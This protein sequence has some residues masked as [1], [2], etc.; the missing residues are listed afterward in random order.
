MQNL[1]TNMSDELEKLDGEDSAI[2]N[3]RGWFLV[4]YFQTRSGD[5]G[6]NAYNL[7]LE[8]A[9]SIE[10]QTGIRTRQ[11]DNYTMFEIWEKW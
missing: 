4:T 11:K 2:L 1:V 8:K 6:S 3:K 5:E 9:K 7:A 10:R